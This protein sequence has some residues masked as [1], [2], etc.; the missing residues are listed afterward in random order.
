MKTLFLALVLLNPG[1]TQAAENEV[2]AR[3][4][5]AI[6]D[7]ANEM[8]QFRKKVEE[9]EA[10]IALMKKQDLIPETDAEALTK[11]IQTVKGIPLAD[12]MRPN[13]VRIGCKYESDYFRSQEGGCRHL[14]SNFVFSQPS[15]IPRTYRDAVRYCAQLREGGKSDWAI[16]TNEAF[17]AVGYPGGAD[18]H[19]VFEI[20]KS[21]FYWAYANFSKSEGR[22]SL[23]DGV[24]AVGGLSYRDEFLVICARTGEPIP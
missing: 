18:H 11:Q 15:T 3:L 19:F 20:Q 10:T 5:Q 13:G 1:Q 24:T 12:P 21:D 9:L 2:T 16:P 8:A 6:F 14:N 22:G 4:R 23:K 17:H 7:V